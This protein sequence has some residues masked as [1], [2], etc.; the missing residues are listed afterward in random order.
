MSTERLFVSSSFA[1]QLR[2]V[3]LVPPETPSWSTGTDA[4]IIEL[5]AKHYAGEINLHDHWNVGDER[6]IHLSAMAK[7]G[8]GESHIEQDAIFQIVNAGGKKL[9]DGVTDCAFI[10]Q[11]KNVL[12]GA[13]GYSE[14]G[15]MYQN[16]T[17]LRP[18]WK[19]SPRRTWC[20]TVFRNA[21]PEQIRPIFKEHINRT[22]SGYKLDSP[23]SVTLQD[24]NDYFAFPCE[25][26]LIGQTNRSANGEDTVHWEYYTAESISEIREKC[27]KYTSNGINSVEWWLRSPS[28]IDSSSFAIVYYTNGMLTV[29]T[30]NSST[31]ALAPFGTI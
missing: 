23:S 9:A 12:T 28:V 11:L 13:N 4:E 20:N 16:N 5:L 18:T 24:T 27:K 21:I 1:P 3:N 31:T 14:N 25:Y 29:K 26:N 17:I 7:T 22:G 15:Y 2:G 6:V 8:V 30:S 10:V 19:D